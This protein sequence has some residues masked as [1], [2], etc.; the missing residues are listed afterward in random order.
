[1]F[2][3]SDREAHETGRDAGRR[4]AAR[5]R[6]R[7]RRRGGGWMTSERTSP[8]LARW[9]NRVSEVDELAARLDA[10]LELERQHR[11]DALGGVRVRARRN[12]PEVGRPE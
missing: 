2:S 12:T 6:A 9:L 1:M 10:A 8:M 7:V 4:A 11:A 5:A 3:M